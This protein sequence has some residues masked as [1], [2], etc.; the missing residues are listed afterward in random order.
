M[1]KNNST[2]ISLPSSFMLGGVSGAFSWLFTYGI[3]YVKTIVQSQ[4]LDRRQYRSAFHCAVVKYQ[5]EGIRTFFKGMGV[6]MLRS[7]PVNG[8]G[9]V[10][11]ELTRALFEKRSMFA[12]F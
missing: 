2:D 3:D 7:F 1:L 8:I 4:D 10:I 11:F 5:E 9:F 12:A 6:T